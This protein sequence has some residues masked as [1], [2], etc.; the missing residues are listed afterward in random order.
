M[1]NKLSRFKSAVAV[2][3]SKLLIK[4]VFSSRLEYARWKAG[5]G[6]RRDQSDSRSHQNGQRFDQS[7]T[8]SQQQADQPGTRSQLHSQYGDQSL[9][10]PDRLLSEVPVQ[11]SSA[12]SQSHVFLFPS[13]VKNFS[14]HLYLYG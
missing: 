13:Q 11:Q 9:A 14:H 10:R 7:A 12:F 5:G 1:A 6:A 8:R 4:H 3:I 2:F